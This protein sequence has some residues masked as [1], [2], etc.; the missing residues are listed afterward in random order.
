MNTKCVFAGTFDPPTIGHKRVIE[1][2]L[3][4]FDGVVVALMVNAGKTPYFTREQRLAFLNKMYG[5]EPRV[6]II[7]YDKTAADLL[8]EENTVFY[9]RGIRNTVDFEYENRDFFASKKIKSDIINIYIPAEQENLHISS[10]L[11]KNCIKFKKD[12]SA[13]VP[14]EIL[15][16]IMRLT[17]EK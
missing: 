4:M 2:C 5:G 11:V 12:Y 3:K 6:K 9:V 13:Y 8:N 14:E 1:T 7:A 16:D 17:G 10:S 15:S